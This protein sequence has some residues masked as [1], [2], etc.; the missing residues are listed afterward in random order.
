MKEV[1]IFQQ[2]F[3]DGKVSMLAPEADDGVQT[4]WSYKHSAEEKAR[5]FTCYQLATM[6]FPKLGLF[7]SASKGVFSVE[8][9]VTDGIRKTIGVFG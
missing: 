9:D 8:L 1:M 4:K 3:I 6:R 2:L 5:F 7:I